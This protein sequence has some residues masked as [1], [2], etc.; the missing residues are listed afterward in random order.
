M[1]NLHNDRVLGRVLARDLTEREAASVGGAHGESGGGFTC[2]NNS[3]LSDI[4][5]DGTVVCDP[6]PPGSDIP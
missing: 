5:S 4:L 6:I 2:G 1:S 3:Y